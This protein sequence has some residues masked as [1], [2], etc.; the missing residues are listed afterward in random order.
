MEKEVEEEEEEAD[1]EEQME[2]E[3]WRISQRIKKE[4]L[5]FLFP[6][7][8]ETM[9]WGKE[10]SGSEVSPEESLSDAFAATGGLL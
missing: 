1:E 6:L 7:F 8:K 2:A 10:E 9:R 3:G 5:I 4:F